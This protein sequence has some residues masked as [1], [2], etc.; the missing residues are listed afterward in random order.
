VEDWGIGR[1][2]RF[3]GQPRHSA[4]R[5]GGEVREAFDFYVYPKNYPD[6]ELVACRIFAE[7]AFN[8]AL[9]RSEARNGCQYGAFLPTFDLAEVGNHQI[10]GAA[11]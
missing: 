2:L 9:C 5:G 4:F 11:G 10:L 3:L 1:F 7:M 8:R 6:Q